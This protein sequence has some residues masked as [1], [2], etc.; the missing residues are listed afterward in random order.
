MKR[1]HFSHINLQLLEQNS[2]TSEQQLDK[3][4]EFI[5][6]DEEDVNFM[7]DL[8]QMHTV[9]D[10]ELRQNWRVYTA[11][12][13]NDDDANLRARRLENAAWRLQV[14]RNKRSK[15]FENLQNIPQSETKFIDSTSPIPAFQRVP[16]AVDSIYTAL[17][18]M[19]NKHKLGATC[20]NDI[21]DFAKNVTETVSGSSSKVQT[22][23]PESGLELFDQPISAGE[24]GVGKNYP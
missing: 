8:Y 18:A 3:F 19:K 17:N 24:E 14:M 7:S 12:N 9:S 5:R 22:L 21:L 10:D 6:P 11:M 4:G 23:L 16:D 13:S 2:K 20:L 1:S 15:S